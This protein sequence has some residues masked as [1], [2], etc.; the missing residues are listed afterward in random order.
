MDA[1]SASDPASV[2]VE[3]SAQELFATLRK[4]AWL[5]IILG[6]FIELLIVVAKFA[7]GTVD[8]AVTTAVDAVQ[9]VA[10]PFL[11]CLGIAFGQVAAKFKPPAAY[12]RTMGIAGMLAAPVAFSVVRILHKGLSSAAGSAETGMA[13]A[14]VAALAIVKGAQ[15]GLLGSRIGRLQ[16][17][18]GSTAFQH[19]KIGLAVGLVF[20]TISVLITQFN[21]ESVKTINVVTQGINEIVVPVGCSLILYVTKVLGQRAG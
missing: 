4:V 13:L 7:F 16:A 21:A 12:A 15:Y 19:V 8:G 14:L 1:S 10:W 9:K 20:G 6:L 5:A 11:V 17:Q 2:P 3:S 18:P